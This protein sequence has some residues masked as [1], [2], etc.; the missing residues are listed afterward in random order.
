MSNPIDSIVKI[1]SIAR[2]AANTLEN[3]R[4]HRDFALERS[5][6]RLL[7]KYL[8]DLDPVVPRVDSDTVPQEMIE[9]VAAELLGVA[10][11]AFARNFN[12]VDS[13]YEASYRYIAYL[14]PQDYK[15][16]VAGA[17][18]INTLL[19]QIPVTAN[20]YGSWSEAV[21]K[22]ME[23]V[24]K[25]E[26]ERK[27]RR[28]EYDE[29]NEKMFNVL[30]DE[31]ERMREVN[32]KELSDYRILLAYLR[33]GLPRFYRGARGVKLVNAALR[34]FAPEAAV[35]YTDEML[36]AVSEA[37]ARDR[38]FKQMQEQRKRFQANNG[39]TK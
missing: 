2:A 6:R 18:I 30:L 12:V 29:N 21:A 11:L 5:R 36:E 1:P 4:K 35:E 17:K 37:E 19:K 3:Q 14:L 7:N 39:S 38:E 9:R 26:Q 28:R 22:H 34:A 13:G 10:E 33:N 27:Q 16:T 15:W 8:V 24:Q 23:Q 20:V 31:L 32:A 25:E